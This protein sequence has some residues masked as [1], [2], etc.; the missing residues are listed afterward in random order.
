MRARNRDRKTVAELADAIRDAKRELASFTAR[1]PTTREAAAARV[2]RELRL[3]VDRKRD[4]TYGLLTSIAAGH[5]LHPEMDD[6]VARQAFIE[7]PEFGQWFR[8][9]CLDAG[10]DLLTTADR[11]ATLKRLRGVIVALELEEEEARLAEDAATINE[12]RRSLKER[13]AAL[14]GPNERS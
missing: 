8:R 9:R 13:A 7:S 5:V 11:D 12:R 4:L 10:G 3:F 1:H 2:E 14:V 6:L